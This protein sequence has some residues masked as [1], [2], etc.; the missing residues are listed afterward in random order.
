[1]L[2]YNDLLQL[3]IAYNHKLISLLQT[4][5]VYNKHQDAGSV[6]ILTLNAKIA[7]VENSLHH[8]RLDINRVESDRI[9][10]GQ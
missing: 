8:L 4:L 3:Q 1:M 9:R 10:K 6:T 7:S 2:T 5:M